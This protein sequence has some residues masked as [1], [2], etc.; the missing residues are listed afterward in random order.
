MHGL[1]AGMPGQQGAAQQWYDG[2]Q[3][4]VECV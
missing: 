2:L 3:L 1:A 4:Q